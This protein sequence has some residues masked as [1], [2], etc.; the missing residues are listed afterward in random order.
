MKTATIIITCVPT[1]FPTMIPILLAPFPSASPTRLTTAATRA[2]F[3]KS[4]AHTTFLTSPSAQPPTLA[5]Q[6][7]SR[8][9]G[10]PLLARGIL[11]RPRNTFDREAIQTAWRFLR[12]FTGRNLMGVTQWTSI[13]RTRLLAICHGKRNVVLWSSCFTFLDRM[14]LNLPLRV[15]IVLQWA[16]GCSWLEKLQCSYPCRIHTCVLHD[17]V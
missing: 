11:T 7:S 17:L 1:P 10:G 15:N 9:C 8:T 13:F 12:D 4:L 5:T 14:L 2:I 3:T 16:L 6:I